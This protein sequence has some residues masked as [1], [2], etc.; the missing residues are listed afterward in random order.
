MRLRHAGLRRLAAAAAAAAAACAGLLPRHAAG[1]SIR[2]FKCYVDWSSQCCVGQRS[3]RQL[4]AGGGGGSGSGKRQL[5]EQ[6]ANPFRRGRV[7]SWLAALA[8]A[9]HP[10]AAEAHLRRSHLGGRWGEPGAVAGA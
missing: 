3:K 8:P 9:V 7:T 5:C 6:R 10:A 1:G 2:C 4:A